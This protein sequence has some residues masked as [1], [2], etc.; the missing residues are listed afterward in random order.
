MGFGWS[1]PFSPQPQ[2]PAGPSFE[3]QSPSTEQVCIPD[4]LTSDGM[5]PPCVPVCV[6]QHLHEQRITCHAKQVLAH[7]CC[8][9]SSPHAMVMSHA[10]H[11]SRAW[12]GHLCESHV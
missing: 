2:Y 8:A 6:F 1:R 9:D 12:I 3:G 10:S 4:Y 7:E 11:G 5:L